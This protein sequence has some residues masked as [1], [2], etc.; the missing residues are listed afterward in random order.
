MG[1]HSIFAGDET[2]EPWEPLLDW[3]LATDGEYVVSQ[4]HAG[5]LAQPHDSDALDMLGVDWAPGGKW[6]PRV[7]TRW[8]FHEDASDA[9]IGADLAERINVLTDAGYL[10]AVDEVTAGG[11]APSVRACSYA[12]SLLNAPDRVLWYLVHGPAVSY[13]ALDADAERPFLTFALESGSHFLCEFYLEQA[14]AEREGDVRAWITSQFR[15]PGDSRLPYLL[16][17][18]RLLHSSSRVSLVFS[19]VARFSR[20]R[21]RPA[22]GPVRLPWG[23]FYDLAFQ[24]ARKQYPEVY[25]PAPPSDLGFGHTVSSWLWDSTRLVPPA[26]TELRFHST[27]PG[28]GPSLDTVPHRTAAEVFVDLLTHYPSGPALSAAGDPSDG[29]KRRF[30]RPL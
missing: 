13:E 10:C 6:V 12:L 29:G 8:D 21:K 5:L 16:R 19:P 3:I 17:R 11:Q 1:F 7:S 22:S 25:A 2:P 4:A 28:S 30:Y 23:R 18:R 20:P 26:K 24:T 27:F 15:G 14:R 9:E